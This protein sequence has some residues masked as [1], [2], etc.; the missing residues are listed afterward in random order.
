M[1]IDPVALFGAL[2]E[3]AQ[4]H[5][6]RVAEDT[7]VVELDTGDPHRAVT[8]DGHVV[9]ARQ[10]V[11]ATHFP[12]FERGLLFARLRVRRE[13]VL[14]G[15]ATVAVR[16]M[17]VSVE[18]DLRAVR[19]VTGAEGDLLMV[20]GAP[21]APGS[22]SAEERRSDLVEWARTHLDGFTPDRVWSAQDCISPDG[23]PFVG[24][25]RPFTHHGVG[26]WGAT[27]F[28]GWGLS[29]GVAA[30]VLLRDLVLG[31][32]P[33]GWRE[34]FTTAR[35]R[36]RH[37]V[38]RVVSQGVKH[39]RGASARRT[40]P[41][42]ETREALAS[43]AGL[44]RGDAVRLQVDGET[45]AVHRDDS[46]RLHAV[47]ATCTHMG[48]LVDFDPASDEWACPCHGSRFS[49]DGT[50]TEGPA[51]EGLRHLDLGPEDDTGVSPPRSGTGNR[52]YLRK[53]DAM[54]RSKHGPSVKDPGLYE[55]LRDDGASKEK[56]ARIANAAAGSSR[57]E[58]GR[59]GG[60]SGDYEDWTVEEL[61]KRAA[62][63]G[64]EGRS[65]MD[66]SELIDALR[67]H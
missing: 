65:S 18:D 57:S 19:R 48:C 55:E 2:A 12:A 20:S 36:P 35:G 33:H 59:K 54:P 30:G 6:A 32:D 28:G 8:R 38:P 21:F 67:H 37:E 47:S 66:K 11:I 44:A 56:A 5:G 23:L 64:I 41:R 16:D 4:R 31:A 61:R 62:V 13:H 29:N 10:V 34:L 45:V 60:K 46:G 25:L 39:L 27:G 53:G 26:V 51:V 42:L 43:L 63:I 40:L 17:Y 52:P 15:R 24:E 49:L 1:L 14:L 7:P 50:V 3:D 9:R 22:A 58:V